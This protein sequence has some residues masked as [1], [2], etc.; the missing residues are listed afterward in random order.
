MT[1]IQHDGPPELKFV[2]KAEGAT[3]IWLASMSLPPMF[4]VGLHRHEGDE[5]LQVISGAARF[6]VNGKNIDIEEGGTVVVPPGTQ[7]GFRVLSPGTKLQV[8]GE[9]EMG[10]WITVI[11]PDG[12][13]HEVEARSHGMMPWHRIPE[14]GDGVDFPGLMAMFASTS[15][16]F[17]Q[18]P[19]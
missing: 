19:E 9:I 11:E 16:V 2:G 17:D 15:S 12:S 8:V 10:E 1:D 5:I 3:R 4:T 13:S 6:H 14:E 7:H 18:A